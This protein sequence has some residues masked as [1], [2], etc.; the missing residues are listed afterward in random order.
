MIKAPRGTRDL[1]PPETALWNFVEATVRDVF[2]AYNFQEIRTPIFEIDRTVRPRRGR[3]NRHRRERNVHLG[4]SRPRR[5]RQ[6]PVPDAS[7]RKHRRRRPRLHRAQTLGARPEQALL[8]R[9]AV[10]PRASAEGPLP[11]VLPDRRG[12]HRAASAGQRISRARRRNSRNAG[13]PA[14]SARHHRLDSRTQFRRLPERP[15]RVQ[16]GP[17]HSART[18]HSARCAPTASAA[19]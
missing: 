6:R 15:R 17:A 5:K 4:R 16:R 11:P 2:R 19:P 3:R 14:R 7:S 18:G 10:P 8:H 13:D 12:S 1:L 9:P